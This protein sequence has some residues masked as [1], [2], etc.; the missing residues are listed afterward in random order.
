[1]FRNVMIFVVMA[2]LLVVALAQKPDVKTAPAP[3]TSAASGEEMYVSYCAVCHGKDGKGNGPAAA[4]MKLP[5]SDLTQLAK[6]NGGKFPTAHIYQVIRGDASLAAH[7]SK[8]MPV[9]GPVFRA[10]S[11]HDEAKVQ[12]RINNLTSYIG[13]MQ[14]K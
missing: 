1:M 12:L 5:P 3:P 4:A 2:G 11:G 8:D 14:A 6:K 13:T 10:L 7:G 9:W